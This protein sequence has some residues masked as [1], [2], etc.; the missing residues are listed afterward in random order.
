METTCPDIVNGISAGCWFLAVTLCI[1]MFAYICRN[2]LADDDRQM[3]IIVEYK[4]FTFATYLSWRM[5]WMQ[6]KR[7]SLAAYKKLHQHP[8]EIKIET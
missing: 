2:P 8:M 1:L 6:R 7:K 4:S 3:E 5:K